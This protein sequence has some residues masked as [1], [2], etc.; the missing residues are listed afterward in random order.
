[1]FVF[2]Y[3]HCP[4]V[5]PKANFCGLWASFLRREYPVLLEGCVAQSIGVP[6]CL[7]PLL[8]TVGS[9]QSSLSERENTITPREFILCCSYQQ[10]KA[11][12]I[13]KHWA[14]SPWSLKT[15]W[16]SPLSVTGNLTSL[17]QRKVLCW[18]MPLP[19]SKWSPRSC[20][21]EDTLPCVVSRG[22]P[23]ARPEQRCVRHQK[24]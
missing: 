9:G 2:P 21:C 20:V 6:V 11:K 13:S 8:L 19:D 22:I 1:M 17:W 12:I 16:E 24:L 14:F 3:I 23:R 10:W 15:H 4:V 7:Q 5:F 18:T